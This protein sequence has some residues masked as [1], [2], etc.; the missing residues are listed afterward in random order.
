MY[1]WIIEWKKQWNETKNN[2]TKQNK[3]M[4]AE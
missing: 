1:S 2:E 4:Q 3:D